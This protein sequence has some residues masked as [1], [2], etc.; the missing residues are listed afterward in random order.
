MPLLEMS[1]VSKSFPGVLAL[2]RVSFSVDRGEIRALMGENGA[3][4]ST[5]IKVLTGVHRPDAGSVALDGANVSP[6]SPIHA[7]ELGI[8]TVYQEV[9]L[10]PNLSV[11]ENVC[12]GAP[13]RIQWRKMDERAQRALSRLNLD[14]DVRRPLGDY[15][16][17]VQQLVA[18]ARAL[19]RDAKV[20]VLDEPTSS[21]DRDEVERLFELMRRLRDGG[22]AVVFVTHFLDQVYSIADSITVLRNGRRV[23]DWRVSDL[24]K[25]N[26]V[27]Q[28]LGR[29]LEDLPHV[30]HKSVAKGEVLLGV[31]RLGKSRVL[32]P[33]SFIVNKGE[34]LGLAGLL[35]S[36]RTETLKLIFGSIPADS[37]GLLS[38]SFGNNNVLIRPRS[39]RSAIRRG[40]GFCPEDRKA[41]GVCPGLSVAE[42]LLLVIQARRGWLRKLPK[43]RADAI[44]KDHV[45]RLQ[46]K[47]PDVQRPIDNLSGGNQQKVLLS[48][49]LAANPDI[50]LLDD[51]TRGIDVGSKLEIRKL[52]TDLTKKG[53]SFLFTSS[54]LEEVINTCDRVVVLRDRRM[55]GELQGEDVNEQRVMEL[56]AEGGA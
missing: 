43:K 22:M 49:W 12:L 24:P 16:T 32:E 10:V 25:A 14:I 8:S 5:L 51:P 15:S 54:E 53:M 37:G 40:I 11:A 23:G 2:D 6:R 26:L 18:I 4:K 9:N 19:D 55:V 41:E 7:Q 52:V 35:G 33:L 34:T 3:G 30:E 39:P 29:D 13:G 50:L 21:L 1:G 36:G 38:T 27:A 17:A 28:M 48:R 31:E 44:V 56:I 20:L 46:I 47:T 42:N 45:E